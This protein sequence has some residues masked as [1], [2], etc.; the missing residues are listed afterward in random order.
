M[1]TWLRVDPI[2][3]VKLT[4]DERLQIDNGLANLW[5]FGALSYSD[6]YANSHELGVVARWDL[7][8]GFAIESHP[9]YTYD[10]Q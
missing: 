10:R 4:D 9:N 3:D 8:G 7:T 1:G 6:V 2:G 5:V